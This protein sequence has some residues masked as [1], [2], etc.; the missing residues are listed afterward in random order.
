MSRLFEIPI[1]EATPSVLTDLKNRYPQA[2]LRVESQSG[3]PSESQSGMPESRFWEIMA[4]LD[5]NRAD[6]AEVLKPATQALSKCST[7]EIT[8]FHD[9]LHEKLY[10][11]DGHAFAARLGSNRYDETGK[12][13]FSVDDFLYSRCAVVANGQAFFEAVLQN[14]RKMP[15]EYTFESL[16]YLP[17]R[18]WELKTGRDDYSYSPDTWAETFSNPDGWPGITPLKERLANF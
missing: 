13:S 18:A 9:L 8:A 11:L 5:W 10:A 17:E 4:M 6:H 1:S 16:L 7:A 2:V 14:P 3:I 12:R 15:K